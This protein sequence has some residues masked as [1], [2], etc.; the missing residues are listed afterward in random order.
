MYGIDAKRHGPTDSSS[1]P[2]L[3]G[4]VPAGPPRQ[5]TLGSCWSCGNFGHLAA[6]CPKK[7]NQYPL[8]CAGVPSGNVNVVCMSEV[9][10]DPLHGSDYGS[11]EL[12]I[13]PGKTTSSIEDGACS[14]K[15]A[16]QK[17]GDIGLDVSHS[18]EQPVAKD[19]VN[20]CGVF[21]IQID[22]NSTDK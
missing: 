2:G 14:M 4:G 6:N 16:K 1:N 5:R 15:T 19:G 17:I 11:N 22:V 3:S 7:V 20:N 12:V 8:S 10:I 13:K 21:D 18:G 9:N